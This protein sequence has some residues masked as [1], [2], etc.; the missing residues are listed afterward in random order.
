[1]TSA[2]TIRIWQSGQR[3]RWIGK[4]SGS[5]FVVL[6]MAK[7]VIPPRNTCLFGAR[8]KL[9]ISFR[10]IQAAAISLGQG[11]WPAGNFA[12]KNGSHR[13]KVRETLL[14]P[15]DDSSITFL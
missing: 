11:R 15:R 12:G 9:E 4:S 1:M 8:P 7:K 13:P 14:L 6:G 2:V 5:G 3:G 10:A